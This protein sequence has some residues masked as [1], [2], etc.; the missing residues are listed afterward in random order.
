MASSPKASHTTTSSNS[1]RS[2]PAPSPSQR[3]QLHIQLPLYIYP[4]PSAWDP[5][6][7]AATSHPTLHF[8][9]IINPSS[10][11]GPSPLP[12]SNYRASLSALKQHSNISI[13]GYIPVTWTRRPLDHVKTDIATYASWRTAGLPVHGIFLDEAPWDPHG[14]E[15]MSLVAREVRAL[16]GEGAGVWIN[17]G[18][19]V[20]RAYYDHADCV[21]A[22]EAGW[23]G[24]IAQGGR[25]G[26]GFDGGREEMGKSAVMVHGCSR[27]RMGE[28]LAG[29]ARQGLRGVFVTDTD[30]YVSWGSG[31]AEWVR[32][33]AEELD[34]DHR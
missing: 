1:H 32:M 6:H 30:G 31:W 3:R 16:L 2:R 4:S 12:D 23:E 28:V 11:P 10:G 14:V 24:W 5:L 29:C 21:T 33:V 25:L 15:Y 20:A 22:F 9:I 27:E 7:T 8:D 26:K 34:P 18:C 19:P 13:Y 17:P